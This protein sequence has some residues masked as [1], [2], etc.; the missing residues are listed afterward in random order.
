[1]AELCIFIK[2][3]D[4]KGIK[5]ISFESLSPQTFLHKAALKEPLTATV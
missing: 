3:N 4:S 1:M 2:D 5:N